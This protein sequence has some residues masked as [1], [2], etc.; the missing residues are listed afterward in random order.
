M[1]KSF[2]KKMRYI[3]YRV[4]TCQLKWFGREN[5]PEVAAMGALYY[6]AVANIFT[7]FL[8]FPLLTGYNL[9]VTPHICLCVCFTIMLFLLCIDAKKLAR[10][11]LKEFRYETP[12]ERL[13]GTIFFWLVIFGSVAGCILSANLNKEYFD[14]GFTVIG[15]LR[16]YLH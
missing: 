1:F 15:Y 12:K 5:L 16:S 2:L 7:L 3:F 14:K 11:V 9:L 6:L 10:K 8:I 13:K 4:Y